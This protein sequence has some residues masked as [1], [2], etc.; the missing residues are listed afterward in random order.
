MAF[1]EIAIVVLFVII[2]F[3]VLIYA[4]VSGLL[5][6]ILVKTIEKYSCEGF[7]IYKTYVGDYSN[8]GPYFTEANSINPNLQKIGIYYDDPKRVSFRR[9]GN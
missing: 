9:K 4:I 8:A 2:I 1:I 6:P 7:F 5:E 3:S